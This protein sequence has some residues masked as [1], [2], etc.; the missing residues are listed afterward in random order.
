MIGRNPALAVSSSPSS[1]TPTRLTG[2]GLTG[3][4]EGTGPEAPVVTCLPAAGHVV[5]RMPQ[6][7]WQEETAL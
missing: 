4:P 2:Q 7:H 5:S 1:P 3:E 6:A